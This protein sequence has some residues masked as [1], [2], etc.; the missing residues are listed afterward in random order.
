MTNKTKR[1]QTESN[2]IK[3][4]ETNA[5]K[6]NPLYF[7][8]PIPESELIEALTKHFNDVRKMHVNAV[9]F[10]VKENRLMVGVLPA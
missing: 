4:S 5:V 1:N 8:V 3:P 10:R 2:G 9:A 6:N 7:E